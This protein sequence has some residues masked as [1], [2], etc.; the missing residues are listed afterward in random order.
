MQ[1]TKREKKNRKSQEIK[2]E[3]QNQDEIDLKTNDTKYEN[4]EKKK[5]AISVKYFIDN[6]EK[7]KFI[8]NFTVDEQN[9]VLIQA[10]WQ[11]IL[12]RNRWLQRQN[13]TILY[14][15]SLSAT[16]NNEG[17]WTQI[18]MDYCI[19]LIDDN[20][21]EHVCLWIQSEQYMKQL[22]TDNIGG[23]A[24]NDNNNNE[25]QPLMSN[26]IDTIANS[27]VDIRKSFII[28]EVLLIL[29]MIVCIIVVSL[30]MENIFGKIFL[31]VV[32]SIILILTCGFHFCLLDPVIVALR[33][34]D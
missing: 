25:H 2:Y 29:I 19:P 30:L 31:I 22:K 8:L 15:K 4:D 20:N 12:Q 16:I 6:D 14:S 5:M 26:N 10:I 21:D 9:K 13:R 11:Q 34:Q 28:I 24:I 23:N 18:P 33:K 27:R 32:L 17:L 3:S 1:H 7:T